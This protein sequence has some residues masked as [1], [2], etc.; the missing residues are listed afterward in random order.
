MGLGMGSKD[1]PEVRQDPLG[2]VA[3]TGRCCKRHS[4]RAWSAAAE[5]GPAH[6]VALR[7]IS[8]Q[9]FELDSLREAPAVLTVQQAD[10]LLAKPRLLAI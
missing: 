3:Y 2:Y 6:W 4:R 1:C 8:G 5:R 10:C 7:A 9:I